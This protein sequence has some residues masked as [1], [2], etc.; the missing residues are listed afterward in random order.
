YC[1]S[2]HHDRST[3][4]HTRLYLSWKLRNKNGSFANLRI[5][6]HGFMSLD[7]LCYDGGTRTDISPELVTT[8]WSV[9]GKVMCDADWPYQNIKI[10]HIEI[11]LGKP[12][13]NILILSGMLI[14]AKNS[15]AHT[16]AIKGSDKDHLT[17]RKR[18]Y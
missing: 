3:E 7:L 5:Y 12:F 2:D 11:L 10:L 8:C 6:P 13:G 17:G 1:G 4:Q 15:F 9:T 16:W 18:T 14:L